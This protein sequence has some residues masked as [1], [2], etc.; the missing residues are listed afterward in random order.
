MLFIAIAFIFL[1]CF[2]YSLGVW[3]EK[4]QGKLKHWHMI[5][6]WCGLLADTIGT[7]ARGIMSGSMFQLTFHGITGMLAIMLM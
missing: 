6:F 7:G 4:I 5:V 1:A 3:V 2:L